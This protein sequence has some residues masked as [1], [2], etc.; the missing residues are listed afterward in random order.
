MGPEL[1]LSSH[2][3][4]SPLLVLG[5]ETFPSALRPRNGA[6][7]ESQSFLERVLAWFCLVSSACP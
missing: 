4:L 1:V 3:L 5:D 7:S 6:E 2:L